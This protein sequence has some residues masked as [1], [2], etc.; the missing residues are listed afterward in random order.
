[1]DLLQN[2][3]EINYLY[4]NNYFLGLRDGN[5]ETRT[6]WE[7]ERNWTNFELDADWEVV[8]FEINP[9][10]IVAGSAQNWCEVLLCCGL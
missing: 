10:H 3:I 6:S 8:Y 7:D 9:P 1:M 5:F 4:R 2:K